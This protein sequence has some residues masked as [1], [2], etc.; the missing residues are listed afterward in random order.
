MITITFVRHGQS[1]DNIKGLWAGMRDA[2]LSE[3]GRRQA[4][5]LGTAF[6]DIKFDH[7]YVSPLLRA[8]ATGQAIH[9]KQAHNPPFTVNANLREQYFGLAEGHP[10]VPC[11]PANV[12]ME[13]LFSNNVF[14][15]LTSRHESFPGGESREDVARRAEKAVRECIVPHIQEDRAHIVI[16]S[17]GLCISELIP[18]VIRLDPD[19]PQ[20][21][22]YI[23]HLNTAW[24]RLTISLKHD[25]NGPIDPTQPPPLVVHVLDV[26]NSKHLASIGKEQKADQNKKQSE[27]LA[28]LDGSSNI[29]VEPATAVKATTKPWWIKL[30][31]Q[32]WCLIVLVPVFYLFSWTVR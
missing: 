8:H 9:S 16:A 5:A 18:A 7:V 22:S 19:A 27:V 20:G 4:Q 21:V 17:H 2:P 3:L 6:A 30:D 29:E 14:P 32:I 11:A 12:P 26:N 24:T 23:G 28:C 25:Y 1:E 10:V 13:E 31:P 15:R